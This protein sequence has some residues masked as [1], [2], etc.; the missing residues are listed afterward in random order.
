MLVSLKWLNQY[1]K[2]DDIDPLELANKIT[3]AG[4]EVDAVRPLS[5][6][7]G[8]VIGHVLS[9]EK[10]PQ[11]DKLR[12]CQVDIGEEEPK[13]IVCG[14]PNVKSGQKVIVAK[15][16]AVLPGNFKIKKAKLRG[17]ES[18][19]M[20]CSLQELGIENK[21][22]PEPYQEGIYVLDE[23]APIGEDA[24]TYLGLDDTILEFD[25][26]PNRGDCLSILGVAYEVGAILDRKVELPIEYSEVYKE[27]PAF[28]V[29]IETANCDLYYAKKVKIGPSPLWMQQAL[30][31]SNI[32]PINNV[33]DITNYV[34]LEL[35]QPLHAFD[36]NKL[37]HQRIVVR[38][39]KNGEVL[40]TLDEI[41]RKL[42]ETDLVI[43][44]GEKP[45]AL[46]GVMG[47]LDTA[48][49]DETTDVLLESAIFDPIS[50][51]QTYTRLDLRSESSIRFEKK[52]DPERTLYALNRAALLMVE[53]C[54]GEIDYYLSVS[55]QR[56]YK[57]RVIELSVKKVEKVLGIAITEEEIDDI[58]R[59]LQ[60][61]FTI[62]GDIFHVI[63][64]SR[65]QDIAIEEDLIE[66]I[67]RIYG[68]E[69][70][71]DTLPLTETTGRLTPVQKKRRMV[72]DTL[73][74]CGLTEVVTY[75][76][77]SEKEVYRFKMR[78][79]DTF[80]PIVL[81]MPMSEDRKY[82]RH[83]LIPSL[84][85]VIRYNEARKVDNVQIFELARR[86][87][88]TKE[89]PVEEDVVA[90]ALTGLALD[91]PWQK[92]KEAVDFFYVKG[93]LEAVFEKLRI[94]HQLTFVPTDDKLGQDYHGGRTAYIKLDDKIVGI[95][96]QVH[97]EVQKEYD[98]HETY[99]FEV[100]L[101]HVLQLSTPR[102]QAYETISR[103][104]GMTRD[105]AL[106][107]D[108]EITAGDI[109]GTIKEN[110][111]KLLKS[112]SVFDVYTGEHVPAGKKSVAFTLYF[113]LTDRTLTEEEVTKITEK[114][115]KAL[116]N[117]YQATLRS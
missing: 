3:H 88:W 37:D 32:R 7:T 5:T 93:I 24:L 57:P 44:D 91:Q 103:Y 52:V 101:D 76:L 41:D 65:R 48:I 16:G 10:H 12:V 20:I 18:H 95:V 62:K 39:A 61:S 14:A 63:V 77:V 11:A 80:D 70:L 106:I 68:Y 100:V 94:S 15:I 49:D 67:I 60:F 117:K 31:A 26:T 58:F 89:G 109:E 54:G 40:T 29:K 43:T 79:S 33:V 66:E 9:V 56:E 98:L 17:V 85:S 23:H 19:G 107:V 2:V 71:N 59:R 36:L 116:E 25:L 115:I 64:P 51:R 45:I 112:V 69:H 46:A 30:I 86:Y 50:V 8:C 75:S 92:K 73:L 42:V 22:V 114:I 38:Q 102:E 111:G 113:E 6:A 55:D 34:M 105:L 28:E 110:G 27:D 53:L 90:G 99:V 72:I 4:I 1:V 83:S 35:G 104:P 81:K 74:A 82:M 78:E 21:L 84:L 13:Q 47:G 108:E 96:G 97:P 87:K